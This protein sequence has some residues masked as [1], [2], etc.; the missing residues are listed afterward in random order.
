MPQLDMSTF[1][2]QIFWL[3]VTFSVLFLIVAQRIVPTIHSIL[4][5][6][7]QRL[8]ND[9]SQADKLRKEANEARQEYEYML[10]KSRKEAGAI[11][12]KASQAIADQTAQRNAKLDDTL[13]RQIAESETRLRKTRQETKEKLEPI[14]V[15]VTSDI[16][17]KLLD[18]SL[19]DNDIQNAIKQQNTAH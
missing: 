3:L 11:L 13:S 2:S 15:A 7:R 17:K 4:E 5:N 8:T 10:A 14:A 16:I 19:S 9:L 1:A 6:R 12:A 18:V